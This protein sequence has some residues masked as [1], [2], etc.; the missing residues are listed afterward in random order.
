MSERVDDFGAW[1][2]ALAQIA[3]D[4]TSA[5][6]YREVRYRNA[7]AIA[8]AL[9]G[10]RGV[11]EVAGSVLYGVWLPLG[12]VYIGQTSDAK[13]RLWDLPIGESHHLANTFPAEVWSR[14]VVLEWPRVIGPQDIPPSDAAQASLG[15]AFECALQAS[16]Q[17]LFNSIRKTHAGN[18][19]QVDRESRAAALGA[20][21]SRR[22]TDRVIAAWTH[23]ADITIGEAVHI[24]EFGR[25]VQP[26]LLLQ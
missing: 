7:L 19:T 12:L 17:P 5:R 11:D 22:L 20:Q 21:V 2:R 4:D 16:F 1:R 26:Q 13:R 9:V 18:W 10:A 25:V 15:K 3:G 23:L 14:V 6:R 8:R 24:G